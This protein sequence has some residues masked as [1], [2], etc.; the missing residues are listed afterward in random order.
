MFY[1]Q[2]M[3]IVAQLLFTRKIPDLYENQLQENLQILF[4][5]I[6]SIDRLV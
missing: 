1:F 5:K 3:Q 2:K 6:N 4:I